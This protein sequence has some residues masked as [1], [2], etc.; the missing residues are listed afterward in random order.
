MYYRAICNTA[1]DPNLAQN[2]P[3]DE[4]HRRLVADDLAAAAN[5]TSMKDARDAELAKKNSIMRRWL[6]LNK[7]ALPP[8]AGS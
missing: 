8:V 4:N 5:W 1:L 7:D 6:D 2:K 3:A